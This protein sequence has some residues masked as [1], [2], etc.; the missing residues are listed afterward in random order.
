MTNLAIR[1]AE[2]RDIPAITALYNRFITETTV[3]FDLE[4]KS[5]EDRTEWFSSF[6]PKGR[7][8][9]LVAE[10]KGLFAGYAGSMQFRTK[11]AYGTSVETT[12]YI[13][14]AVQGNGIG[15]TLYA[16]LFKELE[17][18]D[19]HRAYAG[20]TLPNPASEAL[21][22]ALGFKDAG[23]FKEVGRKFGKYWDVTWFEKAL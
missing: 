9:L 6:S 11:A 4:P 14:E 8:R 15:R 12:I 13:D 17:G 22:L 20:V 3:T 19:I 21:H 18:E 1:K 5:L 7:Y 10:W 23:T 16:G 2:E